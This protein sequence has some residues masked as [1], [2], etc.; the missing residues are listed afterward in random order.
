MSK[1][2]AGRLVIAAQDIHEED[3]LP[4]MAAQRPRF[5]L[6]EIDITQGENAQRLKE[7]AWQIL[8]GKADGC[9]VGAFTDGLRLADQQKASVVLLVV[10][11]VRQQHASPVLLR[12]LG[13]R[14]R[15]RIRQLLG[16]EVANA[17]SCVVERHCLDSRTHAEE[18][19]ALVERHRMGEHSADV[20]QFQSPRG[21]QVV[22]YPQ[23][24][25]T[26]DEHITREQQVEV[27][28]HRSRERV[29]NG[30][31]R[32]LYRAVLDP[33]EDLGR[34]SAR[35]QPGPRQHFPRSLVAKGTKFSLDGNFHVLGRAY[36][37]AI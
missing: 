6:A 31:Y 33:L 37:S 1:R 2:I 16:D 35:N 20:R 11:N 34:A 17:S 5:D 10:F 22:A 19:P 9:F 18:V 15:S 14:N 29:L 7:N 30:D 12:R 26:M 24:E 4:G 28:G 13:G 27:L 32:R 21:D 25:L 23:G 36:Q 8:E 3:I